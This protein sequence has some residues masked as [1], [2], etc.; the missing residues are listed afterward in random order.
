MKAGDSNP[1]VGR[2][3]ANT[4][5]Y[6]LDI[7]AGW[8]SVLPKSLNVTPHGDYQFWVKASELGIGSAVVPGR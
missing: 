2:I 1:V 7:V 3:E 5:T 8:A 6:V 4:E